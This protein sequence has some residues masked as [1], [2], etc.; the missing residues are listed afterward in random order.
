LRWRES[1]KLVFEEAE[2]KVHQI[3]EQITQFEQSRQFL[4]D[5]LT[6][7]D[8]RLKAAVI[9]TLKH[10]GFK[11]VLDADALDRAAKRED[12][13]IREDG[14]APFIVEVKGLAGSCGKRDV[15]QLIAHLFSACK[16]EQRFDLRGLLIVNHQKNAVPLQRADAFDGEQIENAGGQRCT[17]ATTWDLFK[18]IRDA[19]RLRWDLVNI[20]RLFLHDGRM[21]TVP[22]HYEKVGDV[23]NY[24]KEPGVVGVQ[25]IAALSK[26]DKLAFSFESGFDESTIAS[27]QINKKPADVAPAGVESGIKLVDSLANIRKGMEVWKVNS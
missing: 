10:I 4:H 18:L 2:R 6:E 15:S 27:I 24:Y 8:D 25:L 12:I 23:T 14:E 22:A 16:E 1:I 26:S 3:E 20:R 19:E 5:I 11:N 13:Q 9:E 7:Q 17:L 21:P